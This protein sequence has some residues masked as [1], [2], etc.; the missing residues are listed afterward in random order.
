MTIVR[1]SELGAALDTDL[2]T[3]GGTDDTAVLQEALDRARDGS[4][5]HLILDGP[6]LVSGL[7]VCGNTTIEG[8]AGAGL[9]LAD[10][11]ERAALRN[12]NR[13]RGDVVDEQIVVRGLFVNGNRSGQ[14]Q[15]GSWGAPQVDLEGAFKPGI[16]FFGVRHLLLEDITV[17]NARSFAIWVAT[18]SHVTM[19]R[20]TID[21]NFGPYPG[22]ESAEAQ[23]AYLDGMPRSNLDGIHINGPSR[24]ILIENVRVRSEDDAIALNANDMMSD[25]MTGSN[26]MGPYVGQGPITDV[27]VRDIVFDDAIQGFRLLSSDQLIDRVLIENVGG[28]IRHQLALLSNFHHAAQGDFGSVVFR[29]VNVDPLPSGT[30]ATIYPDWV[31]RNPEGE[32]DGQVDV[33][34]FS[35]RARIENLE[36][37]GVSA[38]LVDSRPLIRLGNNADVGT[39]NASFRIDD[40]DG[41]VVPLKRSEGARLR[42]L[43]LA[44]D[45]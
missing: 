9:Y 33:P 10:G 18:A 37:D 1:A 35:L 22:T 27:V 28:T 21:A 43:R 8:I 16:E 31:A 19:R 4:P 36:L 40:P 38:R 3:G 13:T 5:L 25:D 6:A 7:D 42:S 24:H 15:L 20:I 26:E 12:A 34:L 11:S 44:I 29:N 17:W 30:W 32:A 39:L 45:S 23:R 41:L 2:L 14:V